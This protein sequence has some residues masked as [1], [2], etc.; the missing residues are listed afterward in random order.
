MTGIKVNNLSR[1]RLLIK[2]FKQKHPVK[3]RYNKVLNNNTEGNKLDS[4][5]VIP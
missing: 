2:I 1:K 4:I 3:N 5:S